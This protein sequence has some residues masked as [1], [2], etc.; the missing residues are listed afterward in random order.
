M[1]PSGVRP[2][3]LPLRPSPPS[4]SGTLFVVSAGRRVLSPYRAGLP[5]LGPYLAACWT[6]RAFVVELARAMLMVNHA[7]TFLGRLWLLLNP[8]L[9]A[10]VYYV[11]IVALS[12]TEGSA[13]RFVHVFAGVLAFYFIG[14]ALTSSTTSITGGGALLAQVPLPRLLLPLSSVAAAGRRLMPGVGLLVIIATWMEGWPG[15]SLVGLIPASLL[16]GGA[17]LG[18]CML[19]ATGNVYSRDVANLAPYLPRFGL[20]LSPVLY[21]AAA[22]PLALLAVLQWNPFFWITQAWVGA[23][24][25][26]GG[27]SPA[28]WTAAT[29]WGLALPVIGAVVLLSR[30]RQMAI[31]A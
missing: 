31:H 6:R 19:A 2:V 3:L 15:W 18:V 24:T 11:L 21:S 12:S 9:L 29:A 16:L 4:G 17:T 14:T 25:G 27:M 7:G 28:R 5:P 26:E 13:T 22:L 20:Y 1:L 8:T 23:F 30:E 10:L